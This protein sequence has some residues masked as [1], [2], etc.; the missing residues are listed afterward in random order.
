MEEIASVL[1][2]YTQRM[3][4]VNALKHNLDGFTIEH[5]TRQPKPPR[6]YFNLH[7]VNY[8]SI[9]YGS[10]RVTYLG[11][12]VVIGT[13]TPKMWEAPPIALQR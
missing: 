3:Q 6:L 4:T 2:E 12:D 5:Y 11:D 10:V 8:K 1:P 7:T 13:I 9:F